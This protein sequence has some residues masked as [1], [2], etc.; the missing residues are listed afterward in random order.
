MVGI[1]TH[2][3]R[4]WERRYG[5]LN[6]S[7]T[8]AGDRLY[9]E[10]DVSRLR[11][12][13]ALLGY[14]YSIGDIARLP[15][16][17]LSLVIERHRAADT[18]ASAADGIVHRYLD[19]IDAMD[20]DGAELLLTHATAS[21]S[22]YDVLVQVL[23]PVLQ[24]IGQRWQRGEFRVAQEHAAAALVRS[25]LGQMI[26]ARRPGNT[27]P[28]AVV[29]T[30]SG[31]LHEL[32]A[33]MAAVAASLHGWRTLYLGPNLPASEISQTARKT[34]AQAVLL[35]IVVLEPAVAR[36]ELG[37]VL[38]DLPP[39]AEVL[40]GG[41]SAMTLTNLPSRVRLCRSLNE[42]NAFLAS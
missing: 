20:L 19:A 38:A 41:A 31:E 36:Q 3:L 33:L 14:G 37:L 7:R 1:S 4:A 6:P 34:G 15:A 17:E 10:S 13:K 42:L 11:V 21:L 28:T 12:I 2:A 29:T 32:G 39:P 30:P 35:S 27:A 18:S 23:E 9:A 5:A 22:P 24:A 26:R 16:A 25:H 40:I 8:E